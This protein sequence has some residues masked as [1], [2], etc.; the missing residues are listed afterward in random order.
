[1][2]KAG[3]SPNEIVARLTDMI[4][5]GRLY[6]VVDTLEYLARGGRIGGA[7]KL[8]AELLEI[9][10]IL[11]VKEGQ[12]EPF[13]QLRT[14]KRALARLVEVAVEQCRGGEN[15]H[16]CVIQVAA[17]Q[18]AAA[19]VQELKAKIQVPKIPIYQLPPA[20]VVHAGP[21]TLGIGFFV[22]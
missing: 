19:L 14:K 16:L 15:A 17:E 4:P 21:K 2:A 6:F 5:C 10:P 1:M 20:I 12:V 22:S 3:K 8:L 18:E 13:E 7:R 9:R 11:Q